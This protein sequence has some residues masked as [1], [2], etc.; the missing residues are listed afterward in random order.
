[1]LPSMEV[2][3]I[4]AAVEGL[5]DVSYI[6][7]LEDEFAKKT[8]L[9]TDEY[10]DE[11]DTDD[12]SDDEFIGWYIFLKDG[13]PEGC[14]QRT[15]HLDILKQALGSDA[16]EVYGGSWSDLVLVVVLTDEEHDKVTV[17]W[18]GGTSS[19]L[20]Q[21]NLLG[22]FVTRSK[23]KKYD[24]G[25]MNLVPKLFRCAN[26]VP[27]IPK[28]F[29]EGRPRTQVIPFARS[30]THSKGKETRLGDGRPCTQVISLGRSLAYPCP[31]EKE[32]RLG[33]DGPRT[34]VIS[35]GMSVNC[36][37]GKEDLGRMDLVPKLFHSVGRDPFRGKISKTVPRENKTG[38]PLWQQSGRGRG[39]SDRF[40]V[41]DGNAFNG[42]F[43]L[44]YRF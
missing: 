30:E 21:V 8:T 10:E 11:D 7:S 18:G 36:S 12:F 15:Y 43:V 28:K 42:I 44:T 34:Q 24:F 32:V 37:K 20:T 39:L 29:G 41:Y 27:S 1:M 19:A 25:S 40:L 23:G 14:D 31:E 33:E 4:P 6:S 22:M 16:D 17:T 35:L 3:S 13:P 38:T 5:G 9:I 2:E 26:I